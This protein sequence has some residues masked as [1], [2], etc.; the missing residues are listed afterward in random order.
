MQG[1]G[2]MGMMR[3]QSSQDLSTR[4]SWLSAE[5]DSD[6]D[7]E[8]IV[9]PSRNTSFNASFA[10]PDPRKPVGSIFHS[11]SR[12]ISDRSNSNSPN[13]GES[14]AET[15]VN[16]KAGKV[17]DAASE[18]RRVVEDRQKRSL[19]Q[20]SARSSQRSLNTNI[21]NLTGG[22]ISPTSLTD[23]SYGSDSY[24]VRCICNNSKADEGDAFMVQWYVFSLSPW[25]FGSSL[26][27]LS[28]R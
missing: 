24:N 13:E 20:G 2:S 22:I 6:S 28:S 17:G 14:E 7:D 15:V 9:I 8:P 4:R 19:R 26:A 18:L 11:S 3:S 21:R 27:Y 12:S 5:V 23:S 1:G 25:F 10:L 16:E